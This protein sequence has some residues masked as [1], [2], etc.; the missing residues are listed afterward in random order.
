M[1]FQEVYAIQV[2]D[3]VNTLCGKTSHLLSLCVQEV[4]GIVVLNVLSQ[5]HPR[6]PTKLTP[7]SGIQQTVSSICNQSSDSVNVH[8]NPRGIPSSWQ[9]ISIAVFQCGTFASFL[10]HDQ[11]ET[12]SGQLNFTI[13]PNGIKD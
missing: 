13:L 10:A 9:I 6:E 4:E 2:Q 7:I 12:D 8:I 5:D 11:F 1:C 3:V